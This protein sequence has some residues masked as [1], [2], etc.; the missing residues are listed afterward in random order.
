M[1]SRDAAELAAVSA[2]IE[3]LAV[4]NPGTLYSGDGIKPDFSFQQHRGIPYTGGYGASF[5]SSLSSFLHLSRGTAY[6]PSEAAALV[7]THYIAE[8]RWI[9][10]PGRATL[11]MHT[12]S[13]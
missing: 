10:A 8:A 3:R 7:A 5:A 4:V 12:P 2:V 6:Q 11:P 9:M 13:P 1:M